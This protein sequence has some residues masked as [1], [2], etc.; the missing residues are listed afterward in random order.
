MDERYELDR[1]AVEVIR[2]LE[3]YADARLDPTVAATT[4]MRAAVMAA[5]HRQAALIAADGAAALALAPTGVVAHR[6]PGDDRW[7]GAWRRP[8]AAMLAGTL[9]LGILAGTALAARPGGPLYQA[10]IWTEAANL[11]VAGLARANA[12]VG[13]LQARIDEAEA[14]ATAGDTS[15][16]VAAID[17]YAVIVTE[18]ATGT[19]GDAAAGQLLE[20][21]VSRHVVILAALL[22]QVPATARD[23]IEHALA[24]STNVLHDIDVPAPGAGGNNGNGGSSGNGA[25]NGGSSGNGVT[26][27]GSGDTSG[28]SGGAGNSGGDHA[29]PSGGAAG[30]GEGPASDPT[31]KPPRPTPPGQDR[32]PR[33]TSSHGPPVQ[34]SGPSDPPTQDSQH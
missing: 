16:V 6:A 17:A 33:P 18:A 5:A 24:A 32:T 3:A 20:A 1:G 15:G 27:T 29:G 9:T 11:P 14:A 30:G 25:T 8:V 10:R 12:E 22:Q 31:P 4:R 7:M 34:Q 23:A 13:R 21:A 26:N 28:N 2:R 19:E